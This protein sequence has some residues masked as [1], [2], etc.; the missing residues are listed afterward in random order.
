MVLCFFTRLA[1]FG[2][3][4]KSFCP[5][6]I[7]LA[8]RPGERPPAVGALDIDVDIRGFLADSLFSAFVHLF[9]GHVG[10]RPKTFACFVTREG[11]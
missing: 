7:L 9:V 4:G 11:V 2:R 1:A 3:I 8:G 6:K 5:K 10:H